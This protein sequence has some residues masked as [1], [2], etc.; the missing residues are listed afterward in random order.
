MVQRKQRPVRNPWGTPTAAA[1]IYITQAEYVTG[2]GSGSRTVD[3]YLE[4]VERP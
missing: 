1:G 3:W 2:S 4:I